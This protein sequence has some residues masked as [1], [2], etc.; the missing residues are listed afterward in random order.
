MTE[1]LSTH[2]KSLKINID[3]ARYGTF[4]EIG[5]GQEVARWFFRVGGAAG[6]VAKTMSAYDMTVSDAI[7]GAAK[8]YVSR[9]RLQAM[10]KHEWGLLLERLDKDRG[11]QTAF[12]VFADTV[13]TRSFSRKEDGGGWLGVRFQTSPRTEPSEVIIHTRLWEQDVARQQEALG[14][15]GVNLLHGAFYHHDKPNELIA[16]L[17][18]DLSRNHVEV[19][20]IKCSGPAFAG[21]DNRLLSLQLVEQLHT[22]A[23]LFTAAGEVIEP[24]EI[25]H[26][27]PVLVE[28]G[29]F[30]PVTTVTLDMLQSARAQLLADPAM[31]GKEPVT[32]MEMTLHNLTA[33]G[34]VDSADFLTRVDMLGALGQ[35][36]MISN[37][38]TFHRLARHL[39]RFTSERITM[40]LGI[41]TLEQMFNEKYYADLEGGILESMG[42][43]FKGPVK[44]YVYPAI[45]PTTG[46]Y[47]IAETFRVAPHLE[48]LYQHL[49][50]NRYIEPI[51]DY[52]CR[53]LQVYPRDVLARIQRG[54]AT[55]ETMV[56]AS[57]V[58]LVKQRRLFGWKP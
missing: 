21:V 27:Q 54:D 22:D 42:R 9:D 37:H 28:R 18:D 58:E 51:R 32:L 49:L 48:H 43:L 29:S 12:F 6:T 7:Y 4:A 53:H 52:D 11:G 33:E 2:E 47:I 1:K 38:A 25:L 13:A 40:V 15:L 34:R 19:D 35:T 8:R 55:W 45:N 30:R 39:R 50:E 56:P 17:L 26:N 36:V 5:A 41:P 16:S 44:L 14:V 23:A 10:L 31:Q 46:E 3:A 24:A 57:V 20:M